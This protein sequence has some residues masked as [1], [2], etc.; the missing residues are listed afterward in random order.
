MIACPSRTPCP[1]SAPSIPVPCESTHERDTDSFHRSLPPLPGELEGPFRVQRPERPLQAL[2]PE[3]PRLSPDFPLTPGS[4][5][6]TAAAVNL[7]GTGSD[8]L[9]V[10]CPNCGTGL[11]VRRAYAGQNVR[12]GQCGQKFPVSLPE[13]MPGRASSRIIFSQLY[14]TLAEGPSG[15]PSTPSDQPGRRVGGTARGDQRRTR[16]VAG[17]AGA[18]ASGPEAFEGEREQGRAEQDRLDADLTRVREKRNQ[19]RAERDRIYED[20]VAIQKERDSL[21]AELEQLRADLTLVESEREDYRRDS[22]KL[23]A[24]LDSIRE[25]LGPTSPG[26][27][28]TSGTS[29]RPSSPKPTTY[30]GNCKPSSPSCPRAGSLPRP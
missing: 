22:Q 1:V 11:S 27:V 9:T 14:N 26:E 3:V 21:R 28:G 20:C 15:E 17:R 13:S 16:P 5:D 25:A 30:A 19:L 7:P 8:R 18:P 12:C 6:Y 29:T 10:N 23:G 24:E 2:R 4:S